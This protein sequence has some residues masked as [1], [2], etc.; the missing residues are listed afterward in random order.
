LEIN[1]RKWNAHPV[2]LNKG[3]GTC[4]IHLP[5]AAMKS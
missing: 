1:L 5:R 3:Y 2:P 4:S